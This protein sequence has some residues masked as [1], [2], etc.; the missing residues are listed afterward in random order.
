MINIALMEYTSVGLYYGQI[1]SSE[2]PYIIYYSPSDGPGNAMND[3]LIPC[4]S[5]DTVWKLFVAEK[6]ST[7]RDLRV[8]VTE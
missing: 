5:P 1:F 4:K 7:G 3:V 8:G 2:N 6:R